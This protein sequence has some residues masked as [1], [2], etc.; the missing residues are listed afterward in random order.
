M[1]NLFR[2]LLFPLLGPMRKQTSETATPPPTNP[3]RVHIFHGTFGSELEATDYCLTPI[4]RN[5]PEPLTRDLPD[6]M[7]ITSEVE[8]IFGTARIGSALPMLS[9]PVSDLFREMGDDNTIVM[10]AEAAFGGLP[11]T[12]NDTPKLRYAG[13]FE[14]K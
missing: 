5:K 11:Y 6:A 2:V 13:P 9:G 14:V 8:I 1:M 4:A 3:N 7:I 12:L 10:I